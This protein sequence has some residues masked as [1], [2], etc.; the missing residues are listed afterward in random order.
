[1]SIFTGVHAACKDGVVAWRTHI[2]V[3]PF[4]LMAVMDSCLVYSTDTAEEKSLNGSEITLRKSSLKMKNLK[5]VSTQ[6]HSNRH[7]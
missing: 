7:L 4:K 5:V 6:M 1:M 2:S 3:S